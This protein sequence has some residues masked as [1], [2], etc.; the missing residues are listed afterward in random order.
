M[1]IICQ[2]YVCHMPGMNIVISLAY[3][4]LTMTWF[5]CQT[6]A[7]FNLEGF[8]QYQSRTWIDIGCASHMPD[9]CYVHP[10]TWLVPNKPTYFC[11]FSHVSTKKGTKLHFK[12]PT[13]ERRHVLCV[14]FVS[15]CQNVTVYKKY[16]KYVQVRM[17][18][19]FC[20]SIT[21]YHY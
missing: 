6:N 11:N 5:V 20:L 10:G 4:W 1:S 8:V 16:Q 7:M 3:I 17:R 18:T 12:S 19:Y 9:I 21:V 15:T 14:G 13:A 2:S